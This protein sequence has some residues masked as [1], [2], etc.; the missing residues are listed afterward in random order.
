MKQLKTDYFAPKV[1]VNLVVVE[2]GFI[3]SEGSLS[4]MENV[5]GMQEEGEW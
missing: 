3:G 5:G 4:N 2:K 1:E